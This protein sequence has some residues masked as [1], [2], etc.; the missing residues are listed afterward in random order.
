[1]LLF[2]FSPDLKTNGGSVRSKGKV[3]LHW[4]VIQMD[5]NMASHSHPWLYKG[6]PAS[7]FNKTHIVLVITALLSVLPFVLSLYIKVKG[8]SKL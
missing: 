8:S 4:S 2:L 6:C 5:S 1:M 3:V 7:L